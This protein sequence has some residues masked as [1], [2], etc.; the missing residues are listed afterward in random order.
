MEDD[1]EVDKDEKKIFVHVVPPIQTSKSLRS[2]LTATATPS[3]PV[4]VV[5][6]PFGGAGGAAFDDSNNDPTTLDGR[7]ITKVQ[8]WWGQYIDAI[9]VFYDNPANNT[10]TP[11]KHAGTSNNVNLFTLELMPGEYITGATGTYGSWLNSLSL[12]TNMRTATSVGQ[13]PNASGV[14]SF[15]ANAQDG[16]ALHYLSGS[17]G[18]YMNT[19]EFHWRDV[20]VS[21]ELVDMV[22]KD[23]QGK[24]VTTQSYESEPQIEDSDWF[25][26]ATAE[27]MGAAGTIHHEG[28][29]HWSKTDTW[30]H[31][32]SE[33]HTVGTKLSFS[34]KLSAKFFETKV[35]F[36]LEYSY[37]QTK[38]SSSQLTQ[39]LDVTKSYSMDVPPR[40]QCRA[41][42]S[43][44]STILSGTW[45]GWVK[46]TYKSGYVSRSQVGGG[47]NGTFFCTGKLRTEMTNM[48]P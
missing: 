19:L 43:Y 16:L 17:A 3:G 22:Y 46:S 4:N 5:T 32:F 24:D 1:K 14:L 44:F 2:F 25:E 12:K 11:R 38:E 10:W 26:N 48:P 15:T 42:L 20:I 33:T 18:Y 31:S 30:A 13:D 36:S 39:I 34:G 27:T 9:Q 6:G 35:T 40:K 45:T 47:F 28:S 37:S 21:Q 7:S 41:R 23:Q 8:I 29:I